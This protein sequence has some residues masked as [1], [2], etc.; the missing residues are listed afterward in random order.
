[1]VRH[2]R[3]IV[4]ACIGKKLRAPFADVERAGR[5][6]V[7]VRPKFAIEGERNYEF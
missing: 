4:P 5:R 3:V 2:Y 7:K 6:R 1:M